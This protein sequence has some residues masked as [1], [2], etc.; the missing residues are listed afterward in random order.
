MSSLQGL[1]DMVGFQP[2]KE[3]VFEEERLKKTIAE[4]K[5]LGRRNKDI[6]EEHADCFTKCPRYDPCPICD[7]CQNK[8]S[9]LYVKCQ[10]CQIPI[11]THKYHDRELMIRRNNFKIN[12]SKE[13]MEKIKELEKSK[14]INNNNL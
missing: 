3:D 7:K 14:S 6:F 10:I 5:D 11:C 4:N 12:V 9:H 13:T 2:E 1:Y 8:A